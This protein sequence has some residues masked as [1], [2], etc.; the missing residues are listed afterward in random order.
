MYIYGYKLFKLCSVEEETLYKLYLFKLGEIKFLAM[1]YEAILKV[2]RVTFTFLTFLIS[3]TKRNV[4]SSGA[5]QNWKHR[6]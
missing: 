1:N 3:F 4:S 6:S 5:D 2:Y